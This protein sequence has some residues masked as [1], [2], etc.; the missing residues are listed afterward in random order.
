MPEDTL[1]RCQ[2]KLGDVMSA[3]GQLTGGTPNTPNTG[4]D[5]K[6]FTFQASRSPCNCAYMYGRTSLANKFYQYNYTDDTGDLPQAGTFAG[7]RTSGRF[8]NELLE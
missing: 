3:A 6:Y 5:N 1:Q 7:P 4:G 8:V 2:R